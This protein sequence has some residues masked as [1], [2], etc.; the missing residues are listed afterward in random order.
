MPWRRGL[1]SYLPATEEIGAMGREI[2]S[3][4][5]LLG[6]RYRSP[7][8]VAKL[9]RL[10]GITDTLLLE[11]LGISLKFNLALHSSLTLS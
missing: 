8:Q 9:L 6:Q 2:E 11:R 5:F 4:F 1:V 7:R 10:L 3:S